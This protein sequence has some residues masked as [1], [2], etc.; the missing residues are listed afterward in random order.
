MAAGT[1][2]VGISEAAT[3]SDGGEFL[4]VSGSVLCDFEDVSRFARGTVGTVFDT[5]AHMSCD[6]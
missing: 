5:F 1:A 4:E 2:D 6:G 3:C